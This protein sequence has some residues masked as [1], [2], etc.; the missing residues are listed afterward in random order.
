M[1]WSYRT[2]S[3]L[4]NIRK[5]KHQNRHLAADAEVPVDRASLLVRITDFWQACREFEPSA[6]ETRCVERAA[7]R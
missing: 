7:A 6:T 5:T 2:L 3:S 1:E 4:Q